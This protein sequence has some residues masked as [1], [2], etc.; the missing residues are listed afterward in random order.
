MDTRIKALENELDKIPV[1]EKD[2]IL[3]IVDGDG[4]LYHDLMDAYC[5]DALTGLEEISVA[6]S[7][8]NP[9]EVE[10]S[11][12]ALRGSSA[13]VGGERAREASWWME[14]AAREADVEFCRAMF[15]VLDREI[16]NFVKDVRQVELEDI[17]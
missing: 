16:T 10:H 2:Q 17:A 8:G 13:N 4:E 5:E 12:H 15:D 9:S 14:K 11:A 3:S 7:S 6:L 1:W